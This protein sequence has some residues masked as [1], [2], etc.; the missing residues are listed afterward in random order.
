MPLYFLLLSEPFFQRQLRPALAASWQQRSFE[1]CRG[2]CA[3]LLPAVQA[4]AVRYHT[5]HDE[6]LLVRVADGLPFDR[7]YWRALVGEVLWYGAA[8]IPELETAPDTLGC[9]LGPQQVAT[10]LTRERFAQIHQAHYGARDLVFG[11]G[12]YR[13]EHAG[14][15]DAADVARLADYLAGL[16]PQAWTPADLSA[17]PD[18]ADEQE[19]AD[20]L[21]YARDW[22][23]PLRDLY[24][25]AR[26][27]ERIVVCERL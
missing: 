6:T 11:G 20:E 17:L 15:N 27:Q 10:D 2:L 13:P 12:Y 9:L 26:E 7:D 19:R 14:Y 1:P 3:D 8:E 25:Q 23:P 21:E 24:R 18:L 16:D 4:F 22:L 5:G